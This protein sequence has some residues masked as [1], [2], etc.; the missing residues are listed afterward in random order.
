MLIALSDYAIAYEETL[1]MAQ[2][3]E[4]LQVKIQTPLYIMSLL[5]EIS[6]IRDEM[7]PRLTAF[8]LVTAL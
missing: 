1:H 3:I 2:S 4:L 7:K 5:T 6:P 8:Q